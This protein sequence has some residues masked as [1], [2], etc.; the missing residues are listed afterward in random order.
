MS[1]RSKEGS[2]KVKEMKNKVPDVQ[3]SG[4]IQW[5]CFAG[6]GLF[7]MEESLWLNNGQLATRGPGAYRYCHGHH[8]PFSL[9]SSL[10]ETLF[11]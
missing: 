10:P 8:L 2:P 11:F 7:T 3:A 1:V 4:L 9:L 5:K 6:Y